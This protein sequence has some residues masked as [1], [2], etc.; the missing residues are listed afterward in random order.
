M[1]FYRAPH[2]QDTAQKT[3]KCGFFTTVYVFITLS[4]AISMVGTAIAR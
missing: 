2:K 1:H 3:N 4:S